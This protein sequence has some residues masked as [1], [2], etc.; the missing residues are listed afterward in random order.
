[1]PKSIDIAR[2]TDADSITIYI[3]V[4]QPEVSLADAN[5]RAATELRRSA[6]QDDAR[7]L[8]DALRE[9]L[10]SGTLDALT[11]LL[12]RDRETWLVGDSSG[13]WL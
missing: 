8:R 2:A 12:V 11:T 5:S 10:P 3:T 13:R 1:M 7:T 4:E 9:S 6:H